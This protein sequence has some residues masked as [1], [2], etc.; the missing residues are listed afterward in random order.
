MRKTKQRVFRAAIYL[1]LSKEDGD[2]SF[3]REPSG[4]GKKGESDSIVNQ[5][6]LI[7]EFLKRCP[8]IEVVKEWKDDG[9]TGTTFERPGFSDMM[10][11]VRKG[12]IDCI[13]VKD[14]SRFG[15]EYIETGRLIEKVLPQLGVRFIAINDNY[16][17]EGVVGSA[18]TFSLPFKNLINDSYCRDISIKVRSNLD[19]MR[20]RGD[21]VGNFTVYGYLR[22]QEDKHKLVVDPV[23]GPVVQ[24]IFRWV[25]SGMSLYKVVDKLNQTGVP[26]PMDHKLARGEKYFSDFRTNV[27]GIWSYPMVLRI[28]QNRIYTGDL[29]QGKRT[30]PNYKVKKAIV[31]PEEEWVIKQNTHEPLVSKEQFALVQEVLKLDTRISH[32][33]ETVAPLAGKICCYDCKNSM[34]RNGYTSGRKRYEYFSCS[35]NRADH[36]QCSPH[37]V[38][39][40][41]VEQ[42][43][44][45]AIQ[46]QIDVVLDLDRALQSMK[47]I[48]WQKKEEE[49][50]CSQIKNLQLETERYQNLI[51]DAY[52]DFRAGILDKKE[53]REMDVSFRGRLNAAKQSIQTLQD[54][55]D[56][57]REHQ[58]RIPWV[59]Q[60]KQFSNITELTRNV[61][62]YLVDRVYVHEDKSVEVIF[63]CQDQ[64]AQAM[65]YLQKEAV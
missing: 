45:K 35:T 2:L 40:R 25:L 19:A 65:R 43:V 59:E 57:L 28:V 63:R 31:K 34:Y 36:S 42:A 14:L 20:R 3:S 1:R 12:E 30:T 16:D 15:R 44:L 18:D 39:R 51:L 46:V 64:I 54:S 32:K 8:D 10:E 41:E 9:I 38:P 56:E 55:L 48:T 52:E 27:K 11:A 23:A 26:T 13:V 53:Y 60:F 29:V 24:N 5:R 7:Q 61:V 17:S 4:N 21:F 6:A 62:I 49:H 37:S 47:G 33:E 58:G 50:L 22:S